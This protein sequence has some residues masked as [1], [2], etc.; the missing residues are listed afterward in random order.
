MPLPKAGQAARQPRRNRSCTYCPK[1]LPD[2]C[3]RVQEDGSH[4][5]AH[6][7]CAAVRGV[8]PMYVFINDVPRIGAGQ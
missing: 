8:Q 1:P 4:V 6:R 2:C 7:I 3:V 5:Y